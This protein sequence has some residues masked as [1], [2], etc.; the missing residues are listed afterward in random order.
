[1]T[2]NDWQAASV[3]AVIMIVITFVVV[4]LMNAWANRLNPKG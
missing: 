3:I 1:M 2:L 4:G